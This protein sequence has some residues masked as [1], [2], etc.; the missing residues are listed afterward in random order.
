MQEILIEHMKLHSDGNRFIHLSEV[1]GY[2][3]SH[4]IMC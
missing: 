3:N 4:H 1:C 2:W